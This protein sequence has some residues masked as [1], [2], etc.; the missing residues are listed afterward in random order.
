MNKI[1]KKIISTK[2]IKLNFTKKQKYRLKY[3][4]QAY[5]YSLSLVYTVEN[6]QSLKC[7]PVESG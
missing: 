3:T 6:R 2:K 5:K 7:N 4:K 1:C